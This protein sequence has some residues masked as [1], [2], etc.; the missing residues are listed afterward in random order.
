MKRIFSYKNYIAAILMVVFILFSGMAWAELAIIVHPSNK[1]TL[2]D[3]QIVNLFLIKEKKFPN[4]D[5]A[6]VVTQE[7]NN[8]LFEEFATKVIK[9]NP[10]TVNIVW[11]KRVFTGKGKPVYVGVNA[12]VIT[13]VEKNKDAI[14]YVEGSYVG[15]SVRVV[16]KY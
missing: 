16:K 3:A 15:D 5:K 14:G 9:R 12:D 4:G 7:D 6:L 8:S 2:T 1:A 13:L 11:K 10:R